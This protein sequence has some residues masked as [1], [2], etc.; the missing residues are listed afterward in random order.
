M[1]PKKKNTAKQKID[2]PKKTSEEGPGPSSV[3]QDFPIVGV[4]ASAG[5]LAAF[6]AFFSGMP[7]DVEMG[8][9]F[10]LVQH[11]APDH[12]SLLAELIQRYTRMQVFE[13]EDGMEV[14][15]DCAYII[16]PNRDM[17][18]INGTLQLMEPENPRGHRLPIDFFFRSLAQDQ[19]ELAIC[20]VLSGTGSDGTLGVR[21]VKEEGGMVMVQD[22]GSTEHDGMPRNAIATGLVD[23]VLSPSDMPEQ[24]K[25][26]VTHA[27]ASRKGTTAAPATPRS[28]EVLQKICVLLRSRTGHDFSQYKENTLLRRIDRRMALHQIDNPK[29]YLA[30]MHKNPKEVEAL[31]R[32]LLIGVTNFFRD[33]EAFAALESEA[34]PGLF[35]DKAEGG[36][37]RVWVCGCS[38]G[39]E[40]YSIAILLAEALE[41]L[42]GSYKIQIFATDVDK[43]A[44]EKARSGVFPASIAADVTPGRLERYF[45]Y[46]PDADT[47]QVH[48]YLRDMLIFSEHDVTRDPPFSRIDLISCRNLLIYLKSKVQRKL[49][50]MFH[51]ALNP[52]GVLFL[53]SSESVGDF[54]PL[55]SA[56]DRK[57]KIYR[58]LDDAQGAKRPALADFAPSHFDAPAGWTITGKVDPEVHKTYLGTL[59]K[60]ALLEHYAQTAVLINSHGE[61]LQIYG[62]TGKYLEPAPG[63][64]GHNILV[65]ARNGLRRVLTTALH[66]AVNTKEKARYPRLQVKVNG[67]SITADLTVKPVKSGPDGADQPD[68]YLVILEENPT[69]EAVP[70]VPSDEV[71]D[72]GTSRRVAELEQELRAKEEY[73]QTTLEE[74]ETTNEELKSTNEELQS[75]NE[76]MQSTNEELETSKEEL[77]SLNEELGTVNAELQAKVAELSQAN[78]DMNNLLA[79][80][81]VGT[82]YVD[83]QLRI[84]RFTPAATPVINLIKSDTGRPLGHVVSNM[85]DY[86]RLEEDVTEVLNSLAPK[87]LEIQLKNGAW[88]LMRIRPY[89]TLENVIEGAVLTFVEITERKQLEVALRATAVRE[90]KAFIAQNILATVRQPLLA[91]DQDLRIV[92]ANQAFYTNFQVAEKET[93][94]R[95]LYDLGNRQWDIPDLRRLLEEVLP[96]DTTV[97]DFQVIHEF[98]HIGRR[99]MLLNAR[100][101]MTEADESE[102]ILLAIEDITGQNTEA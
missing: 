38:T 73:L 35:T 31:F 25:A 61:I 7:A 63:D 14:R 96:Q 9:A 74:R 48:K 8:M 13:V 60:E 2:E 47:Y 93:G 44:I 67:G 27:F 56:V 58:R 86:D 101:I 50:P 30:Y 40:V 29:N 24:L 83:M 12:K 102:M 89:R 19:H 23:Y 69:V 37:V 91:L 100:R 71:T 66:K 99:T 57:W 6:E 51:Y 52:R 92:M 32:D 59:T 94:G 49:I 65:M 46:D 70:D 42:E 64:P 45:T 34:I 82:L 75:V 1:T 36:L 54:L 84:T 41:T 88:Y 97:E 43:L 21:T 78:N 33:P 55:F 16:P 81:G 18:L 72:A 17:A 11:L 28:E 3:P 15:P 39:E 68:M 90:T 62:R 85:V 76:E 20:I 10:V 22:P 53:G 5:G 95:L 79:G 4:G 98:E 26:Y 80:T 77:Q 87:E